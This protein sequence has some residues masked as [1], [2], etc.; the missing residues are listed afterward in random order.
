MLVPLF[1]SLPR[2]FVVNPKILMIFY[3]TPLPPTQGTNMGGQGLLIYFF[4]FKYFK[5][6]QKYKNIEFIYF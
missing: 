2:K 6:Y 1:L 3:C 4:C 5:Q